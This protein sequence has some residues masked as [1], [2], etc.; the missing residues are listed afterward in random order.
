VVSG[1]VV[2]EEYANAILQEEPAQDALVVDVPASKCKAGPKL[3]ENNERKDD[4]LG[5][6]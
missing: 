4:G 6:L 2:S 3:P 5:F 1:L